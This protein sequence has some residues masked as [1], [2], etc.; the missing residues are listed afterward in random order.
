MRSAT[1]TTDAAEIRAQGLSQEAESLLLQACDAVDRNG[2]PEEFAL[3]ME[4]RELSRR[5]RA[6]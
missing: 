4:R 6:R 1:D 3:G 5:W 2:T